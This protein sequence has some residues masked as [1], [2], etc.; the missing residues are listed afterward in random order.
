MATIKKD[1]IKVDDKG[2]SQTTIIA[3]DNGWIV[4]AGSNGY[5]IS[6]AVAAFESFKSLSEWLA[7]NIEDN[8]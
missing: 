6:T 2:L 5:N 7:D 3:V 1:T 8:T 4:H